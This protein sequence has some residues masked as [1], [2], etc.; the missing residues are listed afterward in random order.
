MANWLKYSRTNRVGGELPRQ[1]LV[2]NSTYEPVNVCSTRRAI[3][4]LLKGKAEAVE[5]G[6]APIRSERTVFASPLV[7]RL[8]NYVRVPRAD[9]RRLSRRAVLA[10]D[11]FCCQYCGSTRHLT[12]D[13]VVPR[14]RGGSTSW[15]NVVTSCAPC[16]VRKGACL[17]SEV[18]MAPSRKPRPPLPGD[19]VLASQRVVPQAWLPY[20]ESVA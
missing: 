14:S 9:K 5:S 16:N 4:L 18:G 13:H 7:I 6:L 3:V 15:D 17:P 10:R 1:V 2:L 19:F 12:I 20:L 11:G 8:R